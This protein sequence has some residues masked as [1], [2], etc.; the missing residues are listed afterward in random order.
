[1][2]QGYIA[3]GRT[4]DDRM[5]SKAVP[6]QLLSTGGRQLVH[7]L[8]RAGLATPAHALRAIH[9]GQ[10]Q[11]DGI[12]IR[13]NINVHDDAQV[14][15]RGVEVPVNYPTVLYGVRK[16]KL[17]KC[18]MLPLQGVTTL[19]DYLKHR[20]ELHEQREGRVPLLFPS[21]LT[22]VQ[23]LG[24]LSEGLVLLTNDSGFAQRLRAQDAQ[25]QTIYRLKLFGEFPADLLRSIWK[26][27][28]VD[29]VNY[30]PVW[31]EPLKRNYRT[32]WFRVRFVESAERS[33]PMLMDAYRLKIL[34][35]ERVAFGPITLS[36]L[37]AEEHMSRLHIPAILNQFVVQPDSRFTLVPAKGY[38]TDSIPDADS[39][40][41]S[42]RKTSPVA[43]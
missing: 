12:T 21:H 20:S 37:P 39:I 4:G 10:V 16:P 30:G 24:Y 19:Y 22:V 1:M 40:F 41:D 26:G 6:L 17:V 18:S 2:G 5:T 34:R 23:R 11:V 27:V 25:I 7:T 28:V 13:T 38:L 33:L 15:F 29:G 36:Q 35:S 32:G 43:L 8:T 31:V 9:D 3:N 14:L 42:L